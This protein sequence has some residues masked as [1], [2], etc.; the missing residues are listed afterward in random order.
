SSH[1]VRK[2]TARRPVPGIACKHAATVAVIASSRDGRA[3]VNG[4]YGEGH[5]LRLGRCLGIGHGDRNKEI[6]RMAATRV[7][8]RSGADDRGGGTGGAEAH[9]TGAGQ[10]EPVSPVAA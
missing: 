10:G 9:P 7:G 1:S 3:E 4:G 5:R 2:G 8:R 6:S